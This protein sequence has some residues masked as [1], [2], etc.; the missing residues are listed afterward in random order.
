MPTPCGAAAGP[1]GVGLPQ[2]QPGAF[3][4]K[5]LEE[6][7]AHF[8]VGVPVD[9]RPTAHGVENSNYFLRT[10]KDGAQ[11]DWVLTILERPSYA[12]PG[13]VALLDLC[14]EAGLPVARPVRTRTKEALAG[15]AGKGEAAQEQAGSKETGKKEVGKG[16]A[17][18]GAAAV[19]AQ[20]KAAILA[21]MLPG[22]HAETP[23]VGQLEALGRCMAQLHLVAARPKVPI[24]DHPRNLSWLGQRAEAVRDG[25]SR[26]DRQLLGRAL[27]LVAALLGRKELA[28]LP[29]GTIHGDLFRDNLLFDGAKLTG[30]LDFHQAARGPLIYDLAV[31]ANDW[32]SVP[33]GAI[34]PRRAQ[35]LAAAYQAAR[36]LTAAECRLFPDFLL[37]AALAFW[38]SRL[39]AAQQPAP[40]AN[41]RRKDPAEF[42]VIVA[43]RLLRRFS[44]A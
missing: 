11:R 22:A 38:L 1:G 26:G 7:L 6:I 42:R 20:G 24:A 36:P 10:R 34:D 33:S 30:L 17:A 12:G 25:L 19:L 39:F 35:V 14:W 21:P 31:A 28:A 15:K 32:C 9:C 41:P 27:H 29:T 8:D 2:R 16:G 37:Y 23:S 44:L 4:A 5:L 40:G 13:Y 43:H 3:P 18:N